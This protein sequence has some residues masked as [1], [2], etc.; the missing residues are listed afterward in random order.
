[1]KIQIGKM[2]RTL[3]RIWNH[4]LTIGMIAALVGALA[5]AAL[6]YYVDRLR[7]PDPT[8]T[9]EFEEPIRQEAAFAR[10]VH[11]DREKDLEEYSNLFAKD[12]VVVD[13]KKAQIWKGQSE[14]VQRLRD[15]HFTKLLHVS[16]QIVIEPDG[17][18]A[19]AQTD[20]VFSQDKPTVMTNVQGTESWRFR[21]IDGKWRIVSFEFN[22]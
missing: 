18:S 2:H 4:D 15:V 22:Q 19:V 7:H 8:S 5:G 1:M 20:T 13:F 9:L 17:S 10:G 11:S 21:K 6:Q 16:R 14:I 3:K 12:A